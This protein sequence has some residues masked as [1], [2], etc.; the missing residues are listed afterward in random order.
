MGNDSSTSD[1]LKYLIFT[2]QHPLWPWWSCL[3]ATI[4]SVVASWLF[5][6]IYYRKALVDSNEITKLLFNELRQITG[7]IDTTIEFDKKTG[8]PIKVVYGKAYISATGST[9][10]AGYKVSEEN[11]IQ[12]SE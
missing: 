12:K 2:V 3:I 4:I 10:A 11:S 9:K 6:L 7:N 8:K 5:A 1:W